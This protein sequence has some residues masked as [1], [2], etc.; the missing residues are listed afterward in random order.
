M[1]LI[2]II[3]LRGNGAFES[4]TLGPPDP[5]IEAIQREAEAEAEALKMPF[6]ILASHQILI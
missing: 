3:F 5:E 2:W 4:L 1:P 6:R